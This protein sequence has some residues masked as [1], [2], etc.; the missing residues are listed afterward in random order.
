MNTSTILRRA[1]A[2]AVAAWLALACAAPAWCDEVTD[3]ADMLM[4]AFSW[5]ES[6]D[7]L[8]QFEQ[9]RTGQYDFDFRLG[10]SAFNAEMYD[11]AGKIFS[12]M[13]ANDPKDALARFD[14]GR[15]YFILGDYRL[16]KEQLEA[17][18]AML[19]QSDMLIEMALFYVDIR[20]KKEAAAR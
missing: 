19:T 12:R 18:K 16:A 6:Y 8:A 11:V 14:L 10:R 20:L 15:T 7:Y 17:A 4:K 2:L 13:V 9:Q 1:A 3:R 5:R